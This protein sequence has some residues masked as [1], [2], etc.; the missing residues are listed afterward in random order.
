M[1]Y[2]IVTDNYL[3]YEA[4]VRYWWSWPFWQ[5]IGFSNTHPTEAAAIEYCKKHAAKHRRPRVVNNLGSL[6]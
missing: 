1:K 2:R 4:Q 6:K 3:G 5:Q